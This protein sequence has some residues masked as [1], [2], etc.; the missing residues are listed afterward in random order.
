MNKLVVTLAAIALIQTALAGLK[1]EQTQIELHPA[2]GDAT[3][4]GS[5][6]YRNDGPQTVHIKSVHTSCGC[7]TT[8]RQKDEVASG[9]NGEIT[10]TF[11]VG[12][13][14]GVQ[15][16]TVRVETDDATEPVTVLTLRAVIP[17]LVEIKPSFV[18]WENSEP[19]RAKTIMVKLAKEVAAK[20]VNVTSS[21]P[22]FSTKVTSV[23]PNEFEIQVQPHNTSSAANATLTVQP[24]NGTKP[25]Y[26]TLRVMNPSP[27]S[28]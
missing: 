26:A 10:A 4:V 18:Y 12:A 20:A 5:F 23:G 3:A 28:R 6:K 15:Q 27:T 24:D 2:P 16:K 1:W 19:A 13:S 9:E 14:T 17:Q 22:E 8:S 21:S 25:V 7:T 11:K